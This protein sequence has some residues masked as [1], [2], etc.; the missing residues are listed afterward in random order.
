MITARPEAGEHF[1]DTAGVMRATAGSMANNPPATSLIVPNGATG[2]LESVSF[3]GKPVE[4]ALADNMG[5]YD[6]EYTLNAG[7]YYEK[8]AVS[9]LMTES[10]DNFISSTL[11]DFEDS[12]YRAV[13]IADLFPDGYRRF[14]ANAL[15]GDEFIKG[16]RVALKAPNGAPE[17]D[18]DKYPTKGFGFTTWYGATPTSCFPGAGS[19][20]CGTYGADSLTPFGGLAPKDVAPIDSQIGYEQQKFFIAWT[21][22]YLFENQQ[23]NWLDLL[24]VWEL[25]V[26]ANPDLGA[27][28]MEFHYPDGKTYVARYY[29]K[30]TIFGK[31]VQKGIAA[32]VL[33]YANGM[34]KDAYETV[35]GAD[36][37]GDGT[38]E[39]YTAK[40]NPA[41]GA[42]LVKFDAA[43]QPV[44]S[45]GGTPNCT[46]TDSS[47]CTCADNLACQKLKQY[48]AVPFY[49]RQAVSAYGLDLTPHSKGLY[50]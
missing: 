14:I 39:W 6:S 7:S 48:V 26:D 18:A 24:R 49:L 38:P 35:P 8:A 2:Y 16:A 17:V 50:P 41:T 5:E 28:R 3:G 43:M 15:T 21:M 20:I 27:N 13:S 4:N 36:L 29:G 44:T 42:A 33:E 46:A 11:G 30:E 45:G 40:V 1:K 9:M 34:L 10:V 12:R 23:Q 19:T 22:L 25:G 37:D 32:R 47:G 31:V